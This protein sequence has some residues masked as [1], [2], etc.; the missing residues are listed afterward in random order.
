MIKD[1]GWWKDTLAELLMRQHVVIVEQHKSGKLKVT[2]D[3]I[4]TSITGEET[5]C[6]HF[7]TGGLYTMLRDIYIDADTRSIYVSFEHDEG[8]QIAQRVF[9]VRNAQAY[10]E[11]HFT[12]KPFHSEAEQ[13]AWLVASEEQ[14]EHNLS[15]ATTT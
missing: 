8:C 14:Y 9:T 11:A 15:A 2:A 3:D 10:K 5:I 6:I 4:V 13:Q 12:Y 7:H 1:P